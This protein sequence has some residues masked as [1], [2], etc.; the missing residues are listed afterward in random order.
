MDIKTA[1]EEDLIDVLYLLKQEIATTCENP[2]YPP[3]ADYS[4]LKE[5][6]R[7][8]T[9]YILEHHKISIGTFSLHQRQ[10]DWERSEKGKSEAEPGAEGKNRDKV[11]GNKVSGNKVSGNKVSEN[12]V[13]GNKVS[14]NKVSENKVSGNKVSADGSNGDEKSADGQ[15]NS[16]HLQVNHLTIASYWINNDTI[17]EIIGFLEETANKHHVTALRLMV[18]RHNKK[19][20]T[21]LDDLGFALIGNRPGKEGATPLNIFE[22]KLKAAS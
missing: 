8:G 12:K 19:M 2:E 13:S 11:S 21:F 16:K 6:I 1:R 10:N 3:N 9:M 17:Q 15:T 18:N 22:K 4:K 7:K 20:N 5:E 14:E